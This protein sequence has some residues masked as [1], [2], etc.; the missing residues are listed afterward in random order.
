MNKELYKGLTSKQAEESRRLHGSNIL[1]PPEKESLF[2]RFM[3]TLTGPLGHLIPGWQ[4]GDSLVFI[5]E[6]AAIL[7]TAISFSEYYG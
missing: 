7:S 2:K 6:L 3:Q 5:L 4:D 1:T